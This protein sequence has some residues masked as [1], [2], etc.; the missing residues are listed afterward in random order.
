M[1]IIRGRLNPADVADPQFRWNSDCDCVQYTPDGGSTW[2]DAPGSDPRHAPQF[3]LPPVT[4]SN[5]QCDASA[6]IEKWLRDFLT[7]CQTVMCAGAEVTTV[8]NI[9]LNFV[10]LLF[11][12]SALFELILEVAGVIFGVGCTALSGA[13]DDTVYD[14]IKCIFFCRLDENGQL[15]ADNLA[16]VESDLNARLTTTAALIV[17]AILSMQGEVGVSNAGTIG[18]QT[19]DCTDCSCCDT[20]DVTYSSGRGDGVPTNPTTLEPGG[21]YTFTAQEFPG[22]PGIFSLSFCISCCLEVTAAT[23]SGSIGDTNHVLCGAEAFYHGELV[24]ECFQRINYG[25]GGGGVFSITLTF[26]AAGC[27]TPSTFGC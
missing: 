19:G 2:N 20:F 13:F 11:P 25:D 14:E 15:S 3:L 17:N 18:G 26:G 9:A 1:K 21:T 16:L 5:K 7:E 12:P 4:G 23:G 24:G 27:G 6:N 22:F 10:D 8:I